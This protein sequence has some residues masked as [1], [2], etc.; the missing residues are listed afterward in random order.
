MNGF[1]RLFVIAP[2]AGLSIG[3]CMEVT[4]IFIGDPAE[5]SSCAFLL[6]EAEDLNVTGAICAECN[7]GGEVKGSTSQCG[8]EISVR[9]NSD[10]TDD[11]NADLAVFGVA[12]GFT[13]PGVPIETVVPVYTATAWVD[14]DL[15]SGPSADDRLICHHQSLAVLGKSEWKCTNA[16]RGNG[17]T[18]S[19][20]EA[21]I[22]YD[23]AKDDCID[24]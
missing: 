13:Q 16:L 6:A 14:N 12:I 11:G 9:C 3:G 22:K 18:A 19:T 7:S 1:L 20:F 15:E 24:E 21:E 23:S 8:V 4:E 10:L 17:K 2:L 5:T